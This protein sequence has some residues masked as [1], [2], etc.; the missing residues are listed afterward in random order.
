MKRLFLV[1]ALGALVSLAPP[2]VA[3][4]ESFAVVNKAGG[5]L[6]AV[7]LRRVGSGEWIPLAVAP[8]AGATARANF[9]NPDCAFDLRANV[10]GVGQVVWGGVNLCDVRTVTL[11]RDG[12]GR[13]WVDYD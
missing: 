4:V 1:A 12:A 8:A 6:S 3:S 9:S 7:A 2:A 5:G 11:N 13:V 10:A